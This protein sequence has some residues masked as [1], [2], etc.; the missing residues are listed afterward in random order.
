MT[1]NCLCHLGVNPVLYFLVCSNRVK[2]AT[3]VYTQTKQELVVKTE[4]IVF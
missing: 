4:T 1:R 3:A 2:I